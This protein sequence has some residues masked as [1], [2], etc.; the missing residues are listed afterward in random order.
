MDNES[1]PWQEEESTGKYQHEAKGVPKGAARG[2][3]QDRMLEFSYTPWLNSR[4]RHYLSKCDEDIVRVIFRAKYK[5]TLSKKRNRKFYFCFLVWMNNINCSSTIESI[6]IAIATVIAM[7][8]S[9]AISIAKAKSYP[10]LQLQAK[11]YPKLYLMTK[12]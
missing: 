5:G 2:K 10:K 3:S 11:I 1:V 9:I 12:P 6:I 8:I 4:Y 7:A